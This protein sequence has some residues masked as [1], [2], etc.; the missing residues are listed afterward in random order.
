MWGYMNEHLAEILTLDDETLMKKGKRKNEGGGLVFLGI[1]FIVMG[2]AHYL[3]LEILYDSRI[4]WIAISAAVVIAGVACLI[5]GIKMFSQIGQSVAE[6]W[7]ERNHYTLEEI[8]EFNRESRMNSTIVIHNEYWE[9]SPI[10]QNV[11][12]LRKEHALETGLI[13]A[14]WFKAPDTITID[15]MRFVDIAAMWFEPKELYGHYQGIYYV[16]SSGKGEYFR[17]FEPF[18]PW[19]VN[20]IAKRNPMTITAGI[21]QADG[22]D[23]NA[24]K[25]PEAVAELYRRECAKARN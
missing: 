3:F 21:F 5:W 22:V 12:E 13:T 7:A 9:E 20:E 24:Y 25:N 4:T 2:I 16:K 8:Q 6:S 19:L 10:P 18:G 14:H 17:C 23:Y 11:N 1:A 15:I